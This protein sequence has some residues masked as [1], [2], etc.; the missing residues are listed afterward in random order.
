MKLLSTILQNSVYIS[1]HLDSLLSR[2][3]FPW[4]IMVKLEMHSTSQLAFLLLFWN[5]SLTQNWRHFIVAW[6]Q[7][8]LPTNCLIKMEQTGLLANHFDAPTTCGYLH[9][10][11]HGGSVKLYNQP[12][13]LLSSRLFDTIE[14]ICVTAEC[15]SLGIIPSKINYDI[16]I[17][18][19]ISCSNW[20]SKL[21]LP[22]YQIWEKDK[23][24]EKSWVD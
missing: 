5:D 18:S 1:F 24:W 20:I 4:D 11:C 16:L 21:Q 3:L 22:F 14:E 8:L 2:W 23:L 15:Y 9:T 7:V 10:S 17:W 12:Y 19:V 6:D 13:S